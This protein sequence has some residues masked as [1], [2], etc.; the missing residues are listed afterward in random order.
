VT[1]ASPPAI[2]AMLWIVVSWVV[3]AHPPLLWSLRALYSVVA[4]A[5]LFVRLLF[6]WRLS[7]LC[8]F[9]IY[10]FNDFCS[11]VCP[12]IFVHSSN[13]FCLSTSVH[14]TSI[15]LTTSVRSTTFI[16][17]RTPVHWFLS[18]DV[19]HSFVHLVPFRPPTF[20]IFIL[21]LKLIIINLI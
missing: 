20:F 3:A 2:V 13:D 11:F 6:V 14:L 21:F 8:S 9:D 17:P 4:I 10:L 1:R 12:M 7:D 16:R 18:T 5:F 19:R 15:R